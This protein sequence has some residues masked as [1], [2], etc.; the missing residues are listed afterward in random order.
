VFLQH[1][2]FVTVGISDEKELRQQLPISHEFLDGIG[3]ETFLFK[4]G[5]L[6]FE[7]VDSEG[8]MTVPRAKLV[9]LGAPVIDRQLEL[10]VGFVIAEI[11]ECKVV[12]LKTIGNLQAKKPWNKK[13]TDRCSSSTRIML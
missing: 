9:R 7:V 5:V 3:I 8:E 1:F 12:E 4:T 11:N 10:E 6:G 13:S 2:D